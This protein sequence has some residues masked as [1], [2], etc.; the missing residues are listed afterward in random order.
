MTEPTS[1]TNR[2]EPPANDSIIQGAGTTPLAHFATGTTTATG[3]NEP[4]R[5]TGNNT[6]GHHI[7]PNR[8]T[9]TTDCNSLFSNSPTHQTTETYQYASDVVNMRNK[10][11][12]RVFCSNCKSAN[13]CHRTCRKLRNNTPSQTNSHIPTGYHPTATPS[14]LNEQ[15][16]AAQPTG[17]VNNGFG[18][19]RTMN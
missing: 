7:F 12:N 1:H 2:Y 19:K 3:R 9:N 17:T 15:T 6:A 13:H 8:T 11:V 5:N 18:S 10:C 4:W 14:P 16:P